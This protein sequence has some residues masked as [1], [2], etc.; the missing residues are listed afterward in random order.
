M[1]NKQINKE[2]KDIF[3]NLKKHMNYSAFPKGA[4]IGFTSTVLGE[5]VKKVTTGKFSMKNVLGGTIA[6]AVGY[7]TAYNLAYAASL[8]DY[9]KEEERKKQLRS[10]MDDIVRKAVN[11]PKHHVSIN[12]LDDWIKEENVAE[13]S[14]N[15]YKEVL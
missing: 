8:S 5:A 11:D 4:A 1:N 15:K 14:A 10:A 9:E 2:L 13:D 12:D 6:S 3:K 7:F